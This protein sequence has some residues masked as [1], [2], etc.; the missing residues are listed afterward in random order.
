[1]P[2]RPHAAKPTQ[3]STMA[4]MKTNDT[5]FFNLVPSLV[6][7]EFNVNIFEYVDKQG[8]RREYEGMYI[9]IYTAGSGS[10]VGIILAMKLCKVLSQYLL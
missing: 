1:M 7:T 2:P 3:P 6:L 4:N 10:N 5:A 8:R 9:G